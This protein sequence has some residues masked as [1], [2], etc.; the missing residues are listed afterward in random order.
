MQY[1]LQCG[2]HTGPAQRSTTAS[3]IGPSYF[4][5]VVRL[6]TYQLHATLIGR[7]WEASNVRV[8]FG[9]R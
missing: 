5:D 4:L 3:M 1:G 6:R 8:Y 7:Q 2:E 9:G